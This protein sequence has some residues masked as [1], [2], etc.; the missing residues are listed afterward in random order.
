MLFANWGHIRVN[1][2]IFSKWDCI[3]RLGI[4]VQEQE[5]KQKDHT[6]SPHGDAKLGSFWEL[7]WSSDVPGTYPVYRVVPGTV[8]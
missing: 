1:Y 6:E 5:I 2:L 7:R 8:R 4:S 3:V